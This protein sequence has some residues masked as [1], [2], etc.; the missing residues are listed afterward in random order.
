MVTLKLV[1]IARKK[2]N[3]DMLDLKLSFILNDE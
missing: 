1:F 3:K 2:Q